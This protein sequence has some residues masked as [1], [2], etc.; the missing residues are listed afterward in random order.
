MTTLVL[1]FE[2]IENENKTK[3]HTFYSHSKA[4]IIINEK[5]IDDV[6]Q[7][8]YTTSNIQKSLRMGSGWII[9]SVIDHTVILLH[10]ITKRIRT[11]KKMIN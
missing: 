10:Q 1:V 11:S 2:K 8:I 3:Y 6:F 9:D 7:S 5:V 4:E